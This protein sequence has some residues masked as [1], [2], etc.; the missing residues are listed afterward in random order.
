MKGYDNFLLP[1]DDM[2]KARQFYQGVLGLE[3]KFDFSDMGM[4]AYQVGAEEPAIIL[5]DASR[6]PHARPSIWFV[7]EDVKAEYDRLLSKGIAFLSP[8]F[9]IKTGLAVEFD[10]PFGHRFA[11]TD[12]SKMP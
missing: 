10:D 11:L 5:Q 7:V 12:Y 8:P 9:E 4:V 3:V 2:A 6:F 1:V